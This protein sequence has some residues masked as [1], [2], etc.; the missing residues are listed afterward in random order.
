VKCPNGLRE[1]AKIAVRLG[2]SLAYAKSGHLKWYDADGI[3]QLVTSATPSRGRRGML[4]ARAQLKRLGV[5][6]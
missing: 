1:E 6:A 3:L 5:T 2:W 4:N